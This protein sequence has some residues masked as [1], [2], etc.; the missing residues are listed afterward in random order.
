MFLHSTVFIVYFRLAI[1]SFYVGPFRF[2]HCPLL[3]YVQFYKFGFILFMLYDIYWTFRWKKATHRDILHLEICYYENEC[4]CV[5]VAPN[6]AII[7]SNQ[8][9][10]GQHN[11]IT[12]GVCASVCEWMFPVC[13]TV[14]AAMK[15][16]Y[17]ITIWAWC[18]QQNGQM[19]R[20]TWKTFELV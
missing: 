16:V 7:K 1:L 8:C 5:C 17:Q 2:H 14:I 18:G 15:L 12:V 13:V 4:V 20:T 3:F 6:V 19:I 10:D 11:E 9:C